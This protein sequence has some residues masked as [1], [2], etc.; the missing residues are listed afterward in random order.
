MRIAIQ[1]GDASFHDIVA[2]HQFTSKSERV[3]CPTF[4]ALCE[5]LNSK[6]SDFAVMA[7]ENTIAGSI[8]PNYVLIKDYGFKII[9][10]V[11]LRIVL[12]LMALPD[13]KIQQLKKVKSHYMALMQCTEFLAQYP[14]LSIEEYYDTADAAKD[15]AQ[16]SLMGEGAIAPK[17]A[18]QLYG[19]NILA[20]GVETY[21]ENYTRF[22]VLARPDYEYSG[23]T[24][25]ASLSFHLTDSVGSLAHVLTELESLHIN[26]SKIQSMPLLG[27]PFKYNFYIDCEWDEGVNF[28]SALEKLRALTN[29]LIVLGIYKKGETIIS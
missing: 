27:D 16:R 20:E 18:A 7:I 1:G 24:N 17:Y 23:L 21:K 25:K 6:K 15:I 29:D 22:L 12:N 5:S 9:A 11:K 2:I 8:L 28:Q 14:N 19:L 4:K 10:E 26:L 3:K 13:Q